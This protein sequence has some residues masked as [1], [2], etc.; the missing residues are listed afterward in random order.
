MLIIIW[1][2]ALHDGR[3]LNELKAGFAISFC[4][5]VCLPGSA[6]SGGGAAGGGDLAAL[7]G[8]GGLGGMG[9]MGGVDSGMQAAMMQQVGV[10]DAVIRWRGQLL[11]LPTTMFSFLQSSTLAFVCWLP[12]PRL[13]QY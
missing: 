5:G 1:Q 4:V 6:G 11:L 3:Y 2:G 13:G 12:W 10:F 7:G 9:A 8:L